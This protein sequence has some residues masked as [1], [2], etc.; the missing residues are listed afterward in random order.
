MLNPQCLLCLVVF[1]FLFLSSTISWW[2]DWSC[3]C[4]YM[5]LCFC[6]LWKLIET[7]WWSHHVFALCVCV[8]LWLLCSQSSDTSWCSDF[9]IGWCVFVHVCV[10][11]VFV[12]CVLCYC[13]GH[14]VFWH[15][16]MFRLCEWLMPGGRYG[17]SEPQNPTLA[18]FRHI[19]KFSSTS[20]CFHIGIKL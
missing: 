2:S 3:A 8:Y 19:E 9:A 1:M 11:K 14:E 13:C 17:P 18:S 6:L 5:C 4:V 10:S 7:S 12:C 16:M 20:P 15:I